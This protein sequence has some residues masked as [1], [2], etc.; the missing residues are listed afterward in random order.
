MFQHKYLAQNIRKYRLLHGLTQ[1]QLAQKLFVTAQNV[2]KWETGRS[3]PDLENLCMLSQVL[4]IS[5]DRLLGRTDMLPQGRVMVAIAGDGRKTE[6]L[7]FT[8]HGEILE[9]LCLPGSSPN[10]VGLDDAQTVI[11]N[12]IEQLMAV[13][14]DICAI[15]AGIATCGNDNNQRAIQNYLQKL[16]PG[17][18]CQVGSDVLNVIYYAPEPDRCIAVICDTG[19]VVYA[20][21]PTQLQR[22]GGW[23]P[24]WESGWSNY[25]FGRDAL[26]AALQA[27]DGLSAPTLLQE[28][29]EDSIGG[30]LLD[31]IDE[32]Y[33]LPREAICDYAQLVFDAYGRG[34]ATAAQIV[35]KNTQ[36]LAL[37]INTAARSYDCG[38]DVILSGELLSQEEV[39]AR[40]L[41]PKLQPGLKLHTHT[42]P[43]IYGAALRC[44][45]LLGIDTVTFKDAFH[46]NYLQTAQASP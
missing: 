38:T 31:T 39:L 30:N 45:A 26:W 16:C 18:P 15:N 12:G 19:S 32:V 10:A 3:V 20:K 44:C 24:L 17:I 22:I 35:E 5:T 34:D 4:R 8:E 27:R 28:L 21:T 2:S 9:C 11:K 40:H 25:D 42:M 36:Q 7:L 33:K 1:S 13:N 37:L 46:K 14:G 43:Q 29:V 41:Q 23:G 6:F